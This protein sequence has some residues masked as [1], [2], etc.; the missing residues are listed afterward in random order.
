M[1]R[2]FIQLFIT[3]FKQRQ[4]L[5]FIVLITGVI[6]CLYSIKLS[7]LTYPFGLISVSLSIY[8]CYVTGIYGD[9]VINIFYFI[10]SCYGWYNWYNNRK[11]STGKIKIAYCSTRENLIYGI[12][13]LSSY[14]VLFFSLK[15]YTDSNIYYADSFTTALMISGMILMAYRKIEN[16]IY[17]IIADIISVPLYIYKGLNFSAMLF[18]LLTIMAFIGNKKWRNELLNDEKYN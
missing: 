7:I 12:I 1:L 17:F 16:W 6:S 10:M 18:V 13:T 2:D 3:E 15:N 11:K 8:L 14:L 4:W 5:D 9:V